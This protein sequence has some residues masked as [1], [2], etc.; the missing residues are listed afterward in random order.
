MHRFP[1]K[2]PRI[3]RWS[4]SPTVYLKSTRGFSLMHVLIVGNLGSFWI[5]QGW[6]R[7]SCMARLTSRIPCP[8]QRRVPSKVVPMIIIDQLIERRDRAFAQFATIGDK[9][10]SRL[11]ATFTQCG[12]LGCRCAHDDATRHGTHY[13]IN[14]TL[15][16]EKKSRCAC[17]RMRSKRYGP[18]LPNDGESVRSR[19]RSSR[20]AKTSPRPSV[21]RRAIRQEYP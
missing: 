7:R 4:V 13:V 20:P 2:S 8:M 10:P 14:R 15:E 19:R 21:W 16:G 12:K 1:S 11:L 18:N 5:L 6:G 3:C 17:E 9:R